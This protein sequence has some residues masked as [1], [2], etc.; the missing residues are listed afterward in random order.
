MSFKHIMRLVDRFED[1]QHIYM[2]LE[3]CEGG[4]LDE[5]LVTRGRLHEIEARYYL[6]QILLAMVY[7]H[8]NNVI[9]RDLKPLNVLLTSELKVKVGDFG[10]SKMLDSACDWA[11]GTFGTWN[12][13]APEMLDEDDLYQFSVDV[14]AFGVICFML[15]V[16]EQPFDSERVKDIEKN[17]RETRYRL[18][19]DLGLSLEFKDLI[20]KVLVRDSE[21]RLNVVE[22]LQH[23]FFMKG[24]IPVHLPGYT[25]RRT[26]DAG[27]LGAL[28]SAECVDMGRLKTLLNKRF[29]ENFRNLDENR[30]KRKRELMI[31]KEKGRSAVERLKKEKDSEVDHLTLNRSVRIKLGSDCI[32]FALKNLK[33]VGVLLAN[34][35]SLLLNS[36]TYDVQYSEGKDAWRRNGKRK[37]KR[38]KKGEWHR[39]QRGL[40]SGK[41]KSMSKCSKSTI[42]PN[43]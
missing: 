11:C 25:R 39:A 41:A 17:I 15:V 38:G 7:I 4:T 26:P 2:L 33:Y 24:A 35:D 19:V 9:H 30:M 32:G 43:H 28:A 29:P 6:Q 21:K 5:V 22:I 8:R 14:W 40:E 34:G 1:S 36:E 16:G 10:F 37:S 18:P 12:Y 13:I 3:F 20:R 27:E 42:I 23:D 31:E